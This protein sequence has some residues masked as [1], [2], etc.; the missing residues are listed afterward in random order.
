M[1][2]VRGS[3]VSSESEATQTSLMTPLGV[4]AGEILEYLEEHGATTLGR[5]RRELARPAVQV[6]MAV[7]FLIRE[8]LVRGMQRGLDVILEPQRDTVE[9][10]A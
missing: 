4:T 3:S 7:G 6:M 1:V 9:C 8:G 10:G 5:V 2:H